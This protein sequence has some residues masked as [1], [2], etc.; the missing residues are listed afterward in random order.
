MGADKKEESADISEKVFSPIRNWRQDERPR[1]RLATHGSESLS[2]AE[3]LAIL[4]SSGTKGFSALDAGRDLLEKYSSLSNLASCDLSEL[5]KTKGLGP[6]KAVKLVAAFE[7]A[8]RVKA[9][10]FSSKKNI[11]TPADI[12]NYYIPKFHGEKKEKFYT[13]LL[14][15]ANKIIREVQVSEG[16]LNGSTVHAREVFKIAISESAASIIL[17]HNHPSGSPEPSPEDIGITKQLVEAGNIV[18]IKV[19]DHLIIAGDSYT[20]FVQRGLL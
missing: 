1:E 2:D 6:A 9:E 7:I 3:L 15:S 4:I 14:S 13:L 8:K 12:A 11:R 16:T 17:M 10:P 5:K 18:G 20:S 19:L